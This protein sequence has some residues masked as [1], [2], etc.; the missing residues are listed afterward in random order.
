MEFLGAASSVVGLYD[1]INNRL[2]AVR[3]RLRRF[4]D[5]PAVVRELL[6]AHDLVFA[7]LQE[8]S[9]TLPNERSGDF[10][11]H[12]KLVENHTGDA[13]TALTRVEGDVNSRDGTTSPSVERSPLSRLGGIPRIARVLAKTTRTEEA[14]I[15]ARASLSSARCELSALRLRY[16]Q[17]VLSGLHR[18]E[19]DEF[20]STTK[21]TPN[22]ANVVFDFESRDEEGNAITYEGKVKEALT[23]SPSFCSAIFD[24]KVTG[25]TGGGG[26]GKSCAVRALQHVRE[27]RE[28]FEDGIYEISLGMNA[29]T[30]KLIDEVCECIEASGGRFLAKEL[31]GENNVYRVLRK[32][33]EWFKDR[34]MLL[35]VDD[36]WENKDITLDIFAYL[37]WLLGVKGSK[38]VF[39]SRSSRMEECADK[40]IEFEPRGVYSKESKRIL[41]KNADM[42]EFGSVVQEN[43]EKF[44]ELLEICGGLP[45]ALAIAGQLVRHSR[46]LTDPF[47]FILSRLKNRPGMIRNHRAVGY[48]ALSDI[49][50]EAVKYVERYHGDMVRRETGMSVSEMMQSFCVLEKQQFAP[51]AMLQR[52][53]GIH[54]ESGI[55]DVMKMFGDV[56][57]LKQHVRLDRGKEEIGASVH[58]LVQDHFASKAR[59]REKEFHKRLLNNY[60]CVSWEEGEKD[61]HRDW[62]RVDEKRDLYVYQNLLRHLVKGNVLLEASALLLDPRWT[63]KQ[64]RV[65]GI[66][67]V[68]V[69]YSLTREALQRRDNGMEED[70]EKKRKQLHTAKVLE[71]IKESVTLASSFVLSN[72]REVW[73]QLY[74][75]LIGSIEITEIRE[76]L[77]KIREYAEKPWIRC[78]TSFMSQ[79]GHGVVRSWRLTG[80]LVCAGFG[81]NGSVI[82]VGIENERYLISKF[83]EREAG[84]KEVL[85]SIAGTVGTVDTNGSDVLSWIKGCISRDGKKVVLFLQNNRLEVFDVEN[86]RAT[87]TKLLHNGNTRCIDLSRNGSM[88]TLASDDHTIEVWKLE[89]I[90]L[91]RA[92][93]LK[94]EEKV[95]CAALSEEWGRVTVG[96]R[97]RGKGVVEWDISSREICRVFDCRTSDVVTSV[98]YSCKGCVAATFGS[99]WTGSGQDVSSCA[100]EDD[101]FYDSDISPRYVLIWCG[102]S[103]K[104]FFGIVSDLDKWQWSPDGRILFADEGYHGTLVDVSAAPQAAKSIE[105]ELHVEELGKVIGWSEEGEQ[106]LTKAGILLNVVREESLTWFQME[107]NGSGLFSNSLQALGSTRADSAK[108]NSEGNLMATTCKDLLRIGDADGNI[109]ATLESEEMGAVTDFTWAGHLLAAARQLVVEV[110]DSRD[111]QIVALLRCPRGY[112]NE[113][114]KHVLSL[115]EDGGTT[116]VAARI[117]RTT[118]NLNCGIV[119]VWNTIDSSQPPRVIG[120]QISGFVDH[121]ASSRDGRFAVRAY[122]HDPVFSRHIWE[123]SEYTIEV[124]GADGTHFASTSVWGWSLHRLSFDKHDNVLMEW[125]MWREKDQRQFSVWYW[126]ERPTHQAL[127]YTTPHIRKRCYL[128][129]ANR[130]QLATLKLFDRWDYNACANAF[131]GTCCGK[132][133]VLQ[134]ET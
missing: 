117:K 108:W 78:R 20:R 2:T 127:T 102:E 17:K 91:R 46:M 37:K 94:H 116:M 41:L 133:C 109:H 80:D 96:F 110:W 23:R 112:E 49:F 87:S 72:E 122:R 89:G 10:R 105:L 77:G 129:D 121:V 68:V 48:G 84:K 120:N 118:S 82:T 93:E 95:K 39:T 33:G 81:Q 8:L 124:Y 103:Q 88:L 104:P 38:M 1:L 100:V 13:L 57:L 99:Y 19:G 115:S 54:E 25:A 58:D 70:D 76:Y 4:H 134:L 61:R 90:S 83:E 132:L 43:M 21:V 28:M 47:G 9:H 35:I 14:L 16:I 65:G 27:V 45:V 29:T 31:S 34:K 86:K 26:I 79:A 101:S 62:W 69:D 107:K 50:D 123:D 59:E 106:F 18:T 55:Q 131:V 97:G 36:V 130:R 51:V 71:L 30:S 113:C 15:S 114:G 66:R 75:R 56:G 12:L 53:W 98:A 73:F 3:Q 85:C 44:K 22:P 128:Y 60:I 6:E 24:G 42:N 125:D 111:H 126:R 74:G 67:Q 63:V 7:E 11:Q 92:C 40:V 119:C 5:H 32:A 64:I 52:L